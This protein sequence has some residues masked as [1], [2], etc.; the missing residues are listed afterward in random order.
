MALSK[1][2]KKVIVTE[3]QDKTGNTGSSKVQIALL[4]ASIEELSTHLIKHPKD[5]HSKLGLY[6]K[7]NKRQKLLSYV[8]RNSEEEYQKIIKLHGIRDKFK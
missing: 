5:K 4:S 8:K 1:S 7:V 3:I 6:K 2:Q